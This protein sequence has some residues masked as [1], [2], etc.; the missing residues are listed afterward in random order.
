VYISRARPERSA[1][2]E[3]TRSTELSGSYNRNP[4]DHVLMAIQDWKEGAKTLDEYLQFDQ[5][6]K[7]DEDVFYDWKLVKK[8]PARY[9]HPTDDLSY[10]GPPIVEDIA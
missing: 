1:E 9:G 6:K 7:V 10:A 4:A 2:K 8:V 3:I 5:W